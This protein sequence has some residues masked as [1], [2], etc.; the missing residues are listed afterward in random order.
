VA[1]IAN[2]ILEERG[3]EGRIPETVV[4]YLELTM[5]ISAD[6]D[7]EVAASQAA[8]NEEIASGD[9]IIPT[10]TGGEK[11]LDEL[12]APV[13]AKQLSEIDALH[14]TMPDE[15]PRDFARHI[16]ETAEGK[17]GGAE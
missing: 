1:R 15:F 11:A 16:I 4:G 7:A 6:R 2:N 5:K 10:D 9:T 13:I 14:G 12:A 3:I 17:I 8:I